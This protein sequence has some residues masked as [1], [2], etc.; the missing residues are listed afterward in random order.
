ML[1]AIYGDQMR[2]TVNLT[3]KMP[4]AEDKTIYYNDLEAALMIEWE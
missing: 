4:H 1:K 2:M 3:V